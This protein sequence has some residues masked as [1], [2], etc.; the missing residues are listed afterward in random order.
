LIKKGLPVQT[1][2]VFTQ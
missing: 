2:C 1:V